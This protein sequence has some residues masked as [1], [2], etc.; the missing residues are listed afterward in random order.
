MKV[1]Q[2][3]III[4]SLV[5][6]M[7][8]TED[9]TPTDL[10]NVIQL[11]HDKLADT[12]WSSTTLNNLVDRIGKTIISQRQYTG[13]DPLILSDAFTFGA[14]LQK[15]YIEP[16]KAEESKVWGQVEGTS[17]DPYVIKSPEVKQILFNGFNTWQ[18]T[19]TIKDEQWYGAWTSS[20][21]M[22]AFI[23][24]IFTVMQTSLELQLESIAN[25][26]YANFIGEKLADA[27]GYKSGTASAPV[28]HAAH[29]PVQVINLLKEYNTKTSKTLTKDTAYFDADFLKYASMRINT[30]LKRM[31]KMSTMFNCKDYQRH[32]PVE[33]CRVTVLSD[34]AN[35]VQYNLQSDIYNKELVSLPNYREVQYWQGSGTDY[36]TEDTS[37]IEITT[38]S[39]KVI[40]QNGVV[41]LLNDI[42]AIALNHEMKTTESQRN[43]RGHYTNYFPSVD[44]GYINDISENG[45]VF[46]IADEIA[47]IYTSDYDAAS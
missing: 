6:Q 34:F 37:L 17:V 27:E 1:N 36:N 5:T 16:M 35:A 4:N 44:I 25:M 43:G 20:E 9:V 46:L 28:E 29:N 11:G 26:A 23:D 7:L 45:I 47:P 19:V 13:V 39:G 2:V 3:N 14:I 15:I 24:G 31:S 21:A 40:K 8:G 18:M 41:A 22:A 32:T 38:A 42:E 30:M 33:Y 12:E 10:T